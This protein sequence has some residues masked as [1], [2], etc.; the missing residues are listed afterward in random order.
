MVQKG[1]DNFVTKEPPARSLLAVLAQAFLFAPVTLQQRP[2]LFNQA[3]VCRYQAPARPGESG[4]SLGLIL[5]T[6]RK[7]FLSSSS[8]QKAAG[9][10]FFIDLVID[11]YMLLCQA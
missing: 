9:F 8:S 2:H 10:S 1:C 4:L 6:S 7:M 5:W 11:T 3:M